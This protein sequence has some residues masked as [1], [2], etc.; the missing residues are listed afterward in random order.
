MTPAVRQSEDVGSASVAS[1]DGL[2]EG[3]KLGTDPDTGEAYYYN[4]TGET[5]WER[6]V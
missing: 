5:S 1:G 6:P 3:W 4:E 2:P